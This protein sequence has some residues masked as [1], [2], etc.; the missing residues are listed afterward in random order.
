[1]N[2]KLLAL[3][4]DGTLVGANNAVTDE[5]ARAV[6]AARKAGMRV[7]LATGRSYAETM[8]IWRQLPLAARP[9]PMV[10]VGGAMVSEPDTGRTLYQRTMD[11]P[12]A[13]RFA[14]ALNDSGYS[15]LVLVDAWRH[16]VDYYLAEGD[17][18]HVAL[19]DWFRR[20]DVVVRR[21]GDLGEVSDLPEMLRIS[22]VVE[23]A[24]AEGLAESLRAQFDG[25]LNIHPILA[26]NYA[27][28]IVEAHAASADKL[29]AIR[30]VA[31]GHHITMRQVVAVGDDVND[32]L[33]VRRAGLGV[34]MGSSPESLKAAADVVADGSLA[35]FIE[36]LLDGAFEQ[37]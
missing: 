5:T 18:V 37:R 13:V 25:Q 11:R 20:T 33:A 31:Q 29:N 28:W 7:C 36:Q 1:M 32:L 15:A 35:E 34:A 14:R 22:A 8:P 21:V 10:L 4:V 2:Y 16:G 19:R 17:D 24:D 26:P 30:Y 3:D 12:A 27:V 9:E 23:Q 6:A